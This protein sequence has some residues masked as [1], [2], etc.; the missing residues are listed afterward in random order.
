MFRRAEWTYDRPAARHLLWQAQD[1]VCACCPTLLVPAS[2]YPTHGDRATLDHVWP[3]AFDGPDK[4]GNLVLLAHKCNHS[5]HQRWPRREE[6]AV[7]H[8]I[9]ARLGWTA[10]NLPFIIE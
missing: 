7:L 4:L 3:Q 6:V 5:K 2:R 1:G 9:N 8:R 10:P